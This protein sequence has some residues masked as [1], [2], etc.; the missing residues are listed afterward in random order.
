M[1]NAVAYTRFSSEMQRDESIEAQ[2]RAIQE[3]CSKQGLKLIHVYA[4][5]G[6]SGTKDARPEFQNMISACKKKETRNFDTVIVHKLD[7]FAR[8]RYDS[9]IYKKT[10]KENGVKLHSVIENL[11]D[12][13]ESVILESVLDGIAEYYSLNLAREVQKGKKE[14]AYK[15]KFNGGFIP[16]GYD[17][18]PISNQYIINDSEAKTIRKIFEMY[19]I[20]YSLIDITIYLN[21]N[22][23]RTKKG[24]EF[25]KNSIYDILGSEK[26][27]GM[28]VYNKGYK[29]RKRASR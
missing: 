2:V 25:K 1:K 19:L 18:D 27:T 23:Y 22:G 14:N 4:D 12:S 28:Y 5:R 29:G 7:R 16:L 24:Q 9:A 13:P 26:Y 6:I 15:C 10:L 8:N 3:Y 21:E 20:W 17:V 11:N